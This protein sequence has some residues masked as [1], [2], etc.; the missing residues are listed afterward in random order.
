MR[1]RPAYFIVLAV[2]IS[3]CGSNAVQPSELTS[4]AL[5]RAL[6]QQG[7]TVNRASTVPRSSYPF[8]SVSAELLQVNG[9]DVQLFEYASA[10]RADS[11]ASKVSPTG[12]AIGQSQVSW[13][14]TPHF[15]KRD[16]VI[17]LYVG[18]SADVLRM[19][20]GVLGKPFAAG[21]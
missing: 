8:F 18:H 2:G 21:R 5:I 11:D 20:E 13:M 7:A 3:F 15:Y 4:D 19:L 16:R 12:S 6:L 9:T 1:F 17:V 10:A 14:D